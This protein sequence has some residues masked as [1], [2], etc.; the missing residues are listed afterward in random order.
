MSVLVYIIWVRDKYLVKLDDVWVPKDF[1]DADL[2]GDSF[3]IGLFNDLLFL[4]GLNGHFLICR[5]VYPQPNFTKSAFSDR[6][7]CITVN[8][9]MRYCPSTNSP[10]AVVAILL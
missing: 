3:N 8:L 2:T 4:E 7:T 1:Q 5:D 9:P 6:F 10:A